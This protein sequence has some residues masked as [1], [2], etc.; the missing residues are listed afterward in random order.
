MVQLR[1]NAGWGARPTAGR[2]PQNAEQ[3]AWWQAA[4]ELKPRFEMRPGPPVH[5]DLAP[6]VSFAVADQQRAAI[7]VE[8]G[9]AECER[10]ADPEP[11]TPEHNDH[12]AQPDALGAVASGAHD[13]DD[14][15]NGRRIRRVAQALVAWRNAL[16]KA[17]R[18]RWRSA[19]ASA[20]EQW[21]GLHD[22]LLLDDE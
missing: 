17:G 5:S 10:L 2:T 16:V 4:A 18:G 8:V 21:Y 6:L 22:V 12:A 11:S 1:S 13:R 3:P 20:I 15:L 19:P 9:L 7:G 14:V